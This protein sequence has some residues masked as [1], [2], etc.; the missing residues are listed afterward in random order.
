VPVGDR[1]CLLLRDAEL[2]LLTVVACAPITRTPRCIRSEMNVGTARFVGVVIICD[3]VITIP[4]IHPRVA[5]SDIS[6]FEPA[7]TST[8]PCVTPL[9]SD[10]TACRDLM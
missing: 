1:I 7:P 8:V 3:N 9:A 4:S 6:T 10:L 2:V 5:R